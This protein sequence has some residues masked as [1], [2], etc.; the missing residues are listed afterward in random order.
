[1]AGLYDAAGLHL[2][3]EAERINV[4]GAVVE[5]TRTGGSRGGE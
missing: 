1:M 2:A 5:S 3:A 4:L